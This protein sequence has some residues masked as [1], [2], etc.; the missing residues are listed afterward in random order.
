[1]G[2]DPWPLGLDR[3]AA[4]SDRPGSKL[5]IPQFYDAALVVSGT[6]QTVKERV[7]ADPRGSE[8]LF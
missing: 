1:M 6:N 3:G 2:S 7:R 4:S 8:R 5:V